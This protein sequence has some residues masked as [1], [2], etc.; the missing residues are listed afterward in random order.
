MS[1]ADEY[2]ERR[3]N[4]E[5]NA[6]IESETNPWL[7]DRFGSGDLNLA[8]MNETFARH[9]LPHACDPNMYDLVPGVLAPM[10]TAHGIQRCDAC[11]LFPGDLDAARALADRLQEL[12]GS[13]IDVWY[14]GS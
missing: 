12:T 10:D 4:G 3:W 9:M 5:P 11:N 13:T 7:R 14:H 2:A 1:A 8:K 6:V